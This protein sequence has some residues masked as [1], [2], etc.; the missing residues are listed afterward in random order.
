[1]NVAVQDD[2]LFVN[3]ARVV[4]ADI[5]SGNGVIHAINKVLS[6]VVKQRLSLTSQQVPLVALSMMRRNLHL[7]GRSGWAG[8][9]NNADIYP[10]S[11]SEGWHNVHCIRREQTH[12]LPEY[13]ALP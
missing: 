1:M 13:C 12:P 2:N 9:A 11:F 7:P 6:M 4:T 3:D 10:I 8:F 5:V